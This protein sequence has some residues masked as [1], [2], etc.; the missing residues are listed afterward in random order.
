M[1]SHLYQEQMAQEI[2]ERIKVK[3]VQEFEVLYRQLSKGR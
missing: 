3:Y 2:A 1:T